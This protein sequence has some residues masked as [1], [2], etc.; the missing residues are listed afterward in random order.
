MLF[1]Y[2]HQA[3]SNVACG[4]P[5]LVVEVRHHLYDVTGGVPFH[6][7]LSLQGHS[8]CFH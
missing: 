3:G 5:R 7:S 6:V 8:A 1:W 2:L 4:L